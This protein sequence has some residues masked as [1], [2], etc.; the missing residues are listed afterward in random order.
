[1]H[2]D[3]EELDSIDDEKMYHAW[4]KKTHIQEKIMKMESQ[5]GKVK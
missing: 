2:L 1:M 5:M 3:V 4:N